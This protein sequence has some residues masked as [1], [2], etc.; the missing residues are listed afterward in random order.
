M[1]FSFFGRKMCKKQGKRLVKRDFR[2]EKDEL[3]TEVIHRVLKTL[4]EKKE[5]IPF[6]NF[7]END[8]F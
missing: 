8:E 4:V 3:Y 7:R 1:K 6:C 2:M 5:K